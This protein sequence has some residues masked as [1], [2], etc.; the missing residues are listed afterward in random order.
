MVMDKVGPQNW[1]Y[2]A[3]RTDGTVLTTCTQTSTACSGSCDP[4]PGKQISC[5]N[6]GSLM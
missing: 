1:T 6:V 3:Y 2:T 4:T 5:S